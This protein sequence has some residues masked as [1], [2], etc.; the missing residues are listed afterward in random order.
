M[1]NKVRTSYSLIKIFQYLNEVKKLE[2]IKYNKKIQNKIG[3][4]LINYILFSERNILYEDNNKAKEIDLINEHI[5]Y[6]G[7]YLNGHRNGKGKE[8]DEYDR[9]LFE[10]EYL[11]GKING[12]GKEY[13]YGYL[14]FEG[15]YLN[16]KRYGKGK[17]YYDYENILKFE[18]E[19]L[20]GKIWN[21]IGYDENNQIIYEIKNGKGWIKEYDYG[22]LIFEGE[23]I[24]GEKNGKAKEYFKNEYL[25]VVLIFDGEY[26]NDKK[27]N[28]KGYCHKFKKCYEIK[29]G[30][31]I[32]IEYNKDRQFFICEYKNG[33]RNGFGREF[34]EFGR[35]IF[36]GQY[37]DGAINGIGR[38][39]CNNSIIFQV[40]YINGKRFGKGIEYDRDVKELFIGE[41]L[42]G[43]KVKGKEIINGEIEYE[44][45]YLLNNK[46]EGQGFDKKGNIIYEL[47]NGNGK[48]KEYLGG[49]LKFEG[50]YLNGLRHGKGKEYYDKDSLIF[51]GEYLNGKRN[52]KGKEY[53]GSGKLLF[54]GEYLNGKKNGYGREYTET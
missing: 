11:N 44:G 36:E 5:I 23:Y 49:N 8:Y 47:I 18:G 52:G 50:E 15:E 9:L 22:T 14:K 42:Y 28:G 48:V 40:R 12:H 43:Y 38:E 10:G 29:N 51:E 27:W 53:N 32:M 26:K 37:L 13:L 39:I 33:M 7:G 24:N 4:S 54:E 19:Y 31:G 20:N 6:Q 46:W 1:I 17:E 2:L 3:I 45:F 35:L 30:E 34:D 25:E 21:G 41:Y 16:G